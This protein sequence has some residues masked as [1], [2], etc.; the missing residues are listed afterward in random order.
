MTVECESIARPKPIGDS[1]RTIAPDLRR[2]H[3]V[4]A[5][6]SRRKDLTNSAGSHGTV[7]GAAQAFTAKT[8]PEWHVRDSTPGSPVQ[9]SGIREK[10]RPDGA[11][12]TIPSRERLLKPWIQTPP[13]WRPHRYVAC[14]SRAGRQAV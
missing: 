9:A 13:N 7:P 3:R 8:P 4:S 10:L 2:D 1:S 11:P 5:V 12:A 6:F 14:L